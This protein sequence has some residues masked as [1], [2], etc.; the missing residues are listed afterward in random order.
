[1][2]DPANTSAH[3]RCVHYLSGTVHLDPSVVLLAVV[4]L[5]VEIGAQEPELAGSAAM[6]GSEPPHACS[7]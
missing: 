2:Y 3:C 6:V 4:L 1:M 5:A 7:Y